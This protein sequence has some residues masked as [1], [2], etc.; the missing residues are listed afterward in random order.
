MLFNRFRWKTSRIAKQEKVCYKFIKIDSHKIDNATPINTIMNYFCFLNPKKFAAITRFFFLDNLNNI[1]KFEQYKQRY[2]N[3]FLLTC[4]HFV[5]IY[6]FAVICKMF[7][8]ISSEIH[9]NHPEHLPCLGTQRNFDR[10]RKK[11]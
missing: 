11:N 7:M 1:N 2:S 10:G 4:T 3:T 9:L 6:Y 8:L 5:L